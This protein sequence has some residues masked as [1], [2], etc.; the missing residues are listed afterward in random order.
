MGAFR[1]SAMST[2]RRAETR[3]GRT[4]IGW[5]SPGAAEAALAGQRQSELGRPE[6]QQRAA[7]AR[8]AAEQRRPSVGT[9]DVV[10]DLPPE[11]EASQATL[12]EDHR[13]AAAFAAGMRLALVDLRRVCAVQSGVVTDQAVPDLDPDDLEAMVAFTVRVPAQP[14]LEIQYDSGRRAWIILAPDFNLR[15]V[16]EFK[17]EF[18]DGAVGLGFQ[19]RELGTSVRVVHYQDRFLLIDGYHRAVALLARGIHVVP[20][21]VGGVEI[22]DLLGGAGGI[23]PEAFLGDRPPLL[24]DFWDDEVSAEVQIPAETRVLI[25]EALD[26]RAF[27]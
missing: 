13:L 15:I 22:S 24:P 4:L 1:L 9:K 5:M 6:H 17:T 23:R 11:L 20:A 3:P 21:L 19:V 16:G 14:K 8:R 10:I 18:E 25:V 2:D 12:A 27:G 26:I 7:L